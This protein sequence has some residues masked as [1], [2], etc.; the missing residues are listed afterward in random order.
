MT[1]RTSTTTSGL[2]VIAS[3]L[4]EVLPVGRTALVVPRPGP[5]AEQQMRCRLFEQRNLIDV[6]YREQL[7]SQTLA[8]RLLRDLER[9]DYPSHDGV[10][11]THGVHRI[12]AL[13]LTMAGARAYGRI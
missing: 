8:E 9:N 2:A 12:A 7:S 10:V 13:L 6:L 5:S 11:D 4:A 3:T 1:Q